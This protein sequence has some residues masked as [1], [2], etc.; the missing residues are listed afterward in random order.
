MNALSTTN[1]NRTTTLIAIK[2][3]E[4][5]RRIPALTDAIG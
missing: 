3:S 2:E 1:L 5:E 4:A